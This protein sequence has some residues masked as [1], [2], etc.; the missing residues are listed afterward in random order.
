MFCP[1]CGT[2]N[3][4]HA[5]FCYKCGTKIKNTTVPVI[6]DVYKPQPVRIQRKSVH[7]GPIIIGMIIIG[8]LYTVPIYSTS[9]PFG[10]QYSL[11]L[12]SVSSMCNNAF[13][14]ILGGANCEFYKGIFYVGWIIGIVCLI[15]GLIPSDQN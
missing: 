4:G 5:K 3:K 7:Y 15:L 8:A 10:G 14:A 9:S 6:R 1:E 12:S 13:I 11:T 2:E